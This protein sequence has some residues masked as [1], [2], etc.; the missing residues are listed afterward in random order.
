MNNRLNRNSEIPL[1]QQIEQIIK[2]KIVK[3]EWPAGTKIPSQRKL[4]DIFR[5]NRST[6]TAAI[7][8]LTASGLLEGKRGGGTK[9]TNHTWKSLSAVR[10]LDWTSYVRSGIHR[11]NSTTIQEINRQEFNKG[12]IRPE[13]ENCRLS[14]CLTGK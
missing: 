1:Y 11:P 12:M 9:V 14:S 8:E 3:G 5:V 13:R 6:V 7:D 10:P 4:A 2:E